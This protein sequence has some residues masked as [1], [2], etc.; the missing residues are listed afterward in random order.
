MTLS[1]II[2]VKKFFT[3]SEWD[4]IYDALFEYKNQDEDA[5]DVMNKIAALFGDN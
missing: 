4:L 5:I 3:E 1:D 2:S